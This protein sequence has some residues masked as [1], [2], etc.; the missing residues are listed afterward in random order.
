MRRAGIILALAVWPGLAGAQTEEATA[1]D[2]GYLT[3]LLEDNLSTDGVKVTITGFAGALSSQASLTQMTIADKDGVWLTLRDVVLDWNRGALFSG[4]VD[5]TSLTAAEI[6]LDRVPAKDETPS[7]EARSFA[8]PELPVSV[9]IGKISA[10]SIVLG[11]AVVGEAVT[12]RLEASMQLANGEGSAAIV[13][14]R[15]DDKAA[16]ISLNASYVNATG[17]LSVDLS[18][19]EAADGIAVRLLNVPGAP[20]AA[21]T[22]KGTGPIK[23]FAADVSL[24]TDEVVRLAGS[25]QLAGDDTG[26]GRFNIG[27]AGDLAP[28]FLPQYTEFFGPA[29]SLAAAGSRDPSGRLTLDVF[30]LQAQ[31][32]DLYGAAAIAS[33]GL[34]L[35]FDVTGKLGLADGSP[36]LLPLAADVQT[37]ITSGT[38]NLRYDA[39]QGEEWAGTTT[40][41]GLDRADFKAERMGLTGAGTITRVDGIPSVDAKITFEA[42]GL[43]PT[44]PA[45]AQALGTEVTGEAVADWQGGTG[46]TR[47]S[48]LVLNGEDY[49][50]KLAGSVQ[51]LAAGFATDGTATV[52]FDDL[53]RFSALAGRPLGGAGS[54]SVT[55]EGS[56]LSGQFDVV[57]EVVGTDLRSGIAQVD[58]LLRGKTRIDASVRRDETGTALREVRLTGNGLTATAQGR[59][60][61][62]AND[63]SAEIALSDLAVLGAGYRGALQ[64]AVRLVGDRLTLDGTGRGLAIGQAQ[65]D[66]VL[67]G[68]SKVT[69][70]V[71]FTDAGLVIEQAEIVNPQISFAAKGDVAGGASTIGLQ[72]R[73]A[74]L[75]ILLPEFPG[76]L[77]VSGTAIRDAAGIALDLTGTGPGQIDAAVR[78]RIKGGVA[79]LTIIGTAQAA[80][81]NAFIEPR[82]VSGPLR[83][84]LALRG[85]VALAS[86]SGT[87]SLEGG[88]IADPARN[89]A[90]QDISAQA[91]LGGGSARI[92]ARAG[93]S[94]GG[95][96]TVRGTVGLTRPNPGALAVDL[97]Q[98]VLRDPDLYETTVN[99]ALTVDGPL[100]G[101][102]L[103]AGRLVLTE[104][105]LRIPSTGFGGSGDLPGLLHAGEPAD[106]RA[107]RARAGLLGDAGGNGGPRASA[108]GFG[109]DLQIVAPNRVFLR[110]RGLDAE[111]GG[112][113][114][115]T[116]TT[117]N[118]VPFGAFELIRG[119]LDI[120]GQRLVLSRALL[121][122]EGALVPYLDVAASRTADGFTT[123]VAIT[124]AATDPQVTFTSDPD[125]PEEEVLAR[126]LFGQGL[127][128]L[129]PFQAVELASA[130]ANLAGRGGNGLLARLRQGIGLD[131]LDVRTDDTTGAA[132]VTAGKYLTEKIYTEVTVGQDGESRIDLNLDISRHITLKAGS[133]SNGSSGIGIFLEKDY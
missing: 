32:L 28:V 69:A 127:Q 124:G 29:V 20:S 47:L 19:I 117:D 59:L 50:L 104:T 39:A 27:L 120:L 96:L 33:D 37:R 15:T 130:V 26:T 72:A 42:V 12:A 88:R 68:D 7:P 102:A 34:P 5:I 57:A 53:A 131:N 100:A 75:G 129:S 93:V 101:G 98:V 79:D 106:V 36:L 78:G 2:R 113:V 30:R 41:I 54:V 6:V 123:T 67:R 122:L 14:E 126:L 18:A 114:R 108:G 71:R 58:G 49:D 63:V 84:N 55:G 105:E 121:Q 110:G 24:S 73:L 128:N 10:E 76:A 61:T 4:A 85:P 90:L 48:Q 70:A 44:D 92:E 46:Q 25:V 38:L 83:L 8:L 89:F 86:L 80:L 125:L 35:R 109:L 1:D 3:A 111:L 40:L 64:G 132:S 81:A 94:S 107:T 115:L 119:R 87:V 91:V 45:L 103:I 13:L 60:A 77:V 51:G 112:Q 21:L 116:G 97:S 133:G 22:I 74:N 62:G 52:R 56:P 99:G 118:I 11:E 31:A 82:A 66:R 95:S 65:A 23:G 17:V 16:E 9:T 43:A